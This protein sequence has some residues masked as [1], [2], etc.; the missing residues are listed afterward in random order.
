MVDP[1]S[2]LAARQHAGGSVGGARARPVRVLQRRHVHRGETK[3]G[4]ETT[5]RGK[6]T[7]HLALATGQ[8]VLLFPS[9]RVCRPPPTIDSCIVTS[10]PLSLIDDITYDADPL[11]APLA[12][13][14]VEVIG[15]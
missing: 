11:D 8:S 14:G 7:K 9:G 2:A 1:P 12:Q 13:R 6:D 10:L 4:M 15:P 5:K 3:G